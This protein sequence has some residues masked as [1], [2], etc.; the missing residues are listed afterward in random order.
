MASYT[1][2]SPTAVILYRAPNP[3]ALPSAWPISK[4][5]AAGAITFTLTTNESKSTVSMSCSL[6]KSS[7]YHSQIIGTISYQNNSASS[8]GT[9][10][11]TLPYSGK[12]DFNRYHITKVTALIISGDKDK[13]TNL[14]LASCVTLSYE[15]L[16]TL[17]SNWG[18]LSAPGSKLIQYNSEVTAPTYKFRPF[19]TNINGRKY[20]VER[21]PKNSGETYGP[22]TRHTT[23]KPEY[24]EYGEKRTP[25]YKVDYEVDSSMFSMSTNFP[26]GDYLQFTALKLPKLTL[27]ATRLNSEEKDEKYSNPYWYE[28]IS[29]TKAVGGAVDNVMNDRYYV[30]SCDTT[31]IYHYL[32]TFD[33][34]ENYSSSAESLRCDGGSSFTLPD[35]TRAT[36]IVDKY[37][38]ATWNLNNGESSYTTETHYTEKIT[39]SCYWSG[40]GADRKP[41][42]NSG[43]ITGENTFYARSNSTSTYTY[44]KIEMADT[45]VWYG[46]TFNKWVSG[47]QVITPSYT[48]KDNINIDAQWI[49]NK[50][51]L[52]FNTTNSDNKPAI[53]NITKTF[54]QPVQ[55]P[56]LNLLKNGYR[57]IGWQVIGMEG[58]TY[59]TSL[60]E[61]VSEGDSKG[62][63]V[64]TLEPVYAPTLQHIDYMYYTK[65]KLVTDRL[66]YTIEGD[67]YLNNQF[68]GNYGSTFNS[69][70]FGIPTKQYGEAGFAFFGWLKAKTSDYDSKFGTYDDIDELKNTT[71]YTSD[72]TVINKKDKWVEDAVTT[73]YGVWTYSSRYIMIDNIWRKC[74]TFYVMIDN[75]W[76]K[77]HNS[78]NTGIY[79]K[80]DGIWTREK[81]K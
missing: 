62:N 29:K 65:N 81:S 61:D 49:D 58:T 19:D 59:T 7:H 41:R 46:H 56:A 11:F 23:I 39:Y 32:Q 34:D 48:L 2:K 80:R 31:T 26:K 70:D 77:V 24:G 43:T 14:D 37:F 12:F 16:D 71:I 47:D 18:S 33:F 17:V 76:R 27:R 30:A 38:T 42:T 64:V 9:E 73:R 21:T 20:K 10:S 57:Q 75:I 55:L 36:D 6:G 67:V 66:S 52:K 63:T 68:V 45:P 28:T 5:Y 54:G 8:G 51:K 78:S 15:Y 25:Y 74:S 4:T 72:V 3:G 79:I 1:F 13:K 40:N 69:Y 35:L 44:N 50:Y 60:N 22:I 53:A